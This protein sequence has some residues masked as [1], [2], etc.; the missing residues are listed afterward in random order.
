VDVKKWS[1]L[2]WEIETGE[3]YKGVK[4]M[5]QKQIKD[6]QPDE[7]KK[8]K[9][10]DKFYEHSNELPNKRLFKFDTSE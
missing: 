9:K 7:E 3:P 1:V 10:W 4:L 8:L 6:R 5:D 2:P